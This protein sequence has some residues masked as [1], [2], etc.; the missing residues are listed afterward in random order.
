MSAVTLI[1]R[2]ATTSL[3]VLAAAL[4][5]VKTTSAAEANSPAAMDLLARAAAAEREVYSGRVEYLKIHHRN[6]LTDQQVRRLSPRLS[7]EKLATELA[8]NRNQREW[9]QVRGTLSFD[10]RRTPNRIVT[11]GFSDND[12]SGSFRSV[13]APNMYWRYQDRHDPGGPRQQL[14]IRKPVVVAA[15]YDVLA[16]TRMVQWMDEVE[17]NYMVVELADSRSERG[18]QA[19]LVRRPATPQVIV[20]AWIDTRDGYG[21]PRQETIS[22]RTGRLVWLVTT[23]YRRHNGLL[24]PARYES[25]QVRHYP[26][27]T[28]VRVL[29]VTTTV[30]AAA[31]NSEVNPLELEPGPVPANT[32]VTDERFAPPL[33]FRQGAH[34]YTEE[35]LFELHRQVNLTRPRP[36]AQ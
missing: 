33:V 29:T 35:E 15:P 20:K 9:V 8:I 25:A 28:P 31:L 30:A 12:G 1:V 26:D 2:G 27:G 34:Q 10:H 17:R 7:P 13:F 3:C 22:T 24:Y 32:L 36:P 16:S 19:L 18:W 6:V 23:D 4:V 21:S 14:F 5:L 11:W